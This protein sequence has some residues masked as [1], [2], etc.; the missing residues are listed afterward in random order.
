MLKE[1][2]LLISD[3]ILVIVGDND[4]S[5]I[6]HYINTDLMLIKYRVINF[7]ISYAKLLNYRIELPKHDSRTLLHTVE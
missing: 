4:I 1:M 2:L 5:N 7:T 6:N 3:T